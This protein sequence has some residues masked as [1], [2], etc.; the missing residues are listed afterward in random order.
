MFPSL[1]LL[2]HQSS[3]CMKKNSDRK[4]FFKKINSSSFAFWKTSVSINPLPGDMLS[5]CESRWGGG[6]LPTEV[7]CFI[8]Y[9]KLKLTPGYVILFFIFVMC[10]S[11]TQA[12][13]LMKSQE[14]R[15]TGWHWQDFSVNASS[16][17]TSK[18]RVRCHPIST[19][20][21]YD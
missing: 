16:F 5:H 21:P 4:F 8:Y 10:I 20:A 1:P 3:V 12:L 17:F 7:S 14:W 19:Y 2:S 9:I 18:T 6:N 15:L 13:K 11:Y